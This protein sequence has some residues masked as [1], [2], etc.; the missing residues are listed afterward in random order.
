MSVNVKLQN[1]PDQKQPLEAIQFNALLKFA[2]L[3]QVTHV[4]SCTVLNNSTAAQTFQG[5]HSSII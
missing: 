5:I 2:Y 4:V 3:D 1:N